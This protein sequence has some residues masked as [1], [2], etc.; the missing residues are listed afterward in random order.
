MVRFRFGCLENLIR[1]ILKLPTAAKKNFQQLLSDEN[2]VEKPIT[3]MKK[4]PV[5]VPTKTRSPA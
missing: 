4:A 1:T 3:P 5:P 2:F